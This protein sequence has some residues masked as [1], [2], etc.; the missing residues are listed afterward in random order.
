[1]KIS[2][3]SPYSPPG[4]FQFQDSYGNVIED[5]RR[6]EVDQTGTDL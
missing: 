6:A 2:L 5:S 4:T 3:N 1:M